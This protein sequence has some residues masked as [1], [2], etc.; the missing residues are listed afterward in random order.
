M[1]HRTRAPGLSG[2]PESPDPGDL[3]RRVARLRAEQGLSRDQLAE[4]ADMAPGFIRYLEE[5]PCS[6]TPGTV[7]RLAAALDTTAAELLG[8]TAGRPPG[9]ARAARRATLDRLETDE[10]VRLIAPGGVGR[11]AL[12]DPAGP[13]V[14]PVNYRY[15]DGTVIFRTR[16]GGPLDAGARAAAA[17]E[18]VTV[19]FEV[20]RID[21][22]RR[23]GWS[24]LVRGV[25][26]AVPPDEVAVLTAATV[27]PWAGDGRD[28]YVRV[29]PHHISGRR[30]HTF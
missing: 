26:D 14:F 5:H 23:E 9:G 11:V 4:R 2:S 7:L 29:V 18:R 22:A 30:I 16:P 28:L 13:L 12:A 8:G 27:E 25:A 15:H 17:G 6:L 10:C 21:D 19:G 24:V 20:D 1:D 3:G